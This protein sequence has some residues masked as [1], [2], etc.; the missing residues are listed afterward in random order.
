MKL[1]WPSKTD[2]QRIKAAS[3]RLGLAH[4]DY[5]RAL[6]RSFKPFVAVYYYH[7]GH[8]IDVYCFNVPG[9]PSKVFNSDC[10]KLYVWN[11]RTG[12]YY[13]VSVHRVLDAMIGR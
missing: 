6:K 7:A 3:G 4:L 9:Y 2:L 1:T 13:W 8:R 12:R 5:A 11:E 10:S